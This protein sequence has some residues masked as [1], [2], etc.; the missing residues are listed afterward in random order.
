MAADVVEEVLD[1]EGQSR[2][3]VTGGEALLCRADDGQDR[4]VCTVVV[5]QTE[6]ATGEYVKFVELDED[7]FR[8]DLF[9]QFTDALQ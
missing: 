8:D 1:I 3:R 2:T 6:L 4:V 7:V 5:P 9:K